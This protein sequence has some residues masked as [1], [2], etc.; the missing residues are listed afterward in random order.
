MKTD[1]SSTWLSANFMP[2]KDDAGK[3]GAVLCIARDITENKTLERS[4]INAEKLAS[5]GTLAAGVA[6][7]IN[8]PLG[9]MLGFCDLL[10]RK[11]ESGSQEHDDLKIIERQGLHCKQIVENLLSFARINHATTMDSDI[12]LCIKEIL[13]VVRHSLEMKDINLRVNLGEALPRVS[14]DEGQLRQVF[15]NLINNATSAMPKAACWR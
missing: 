1:D 14:A 6:H 9:V 8:N 15:L 3:I 4:L 13:T 11:K 2:I 10:L 7:E 12:N 5:L